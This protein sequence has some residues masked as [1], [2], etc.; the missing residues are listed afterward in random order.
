[1]QRLIEGPIGRAVA[2]V[3]I[4][5]AWYWNMCRLDRAAGAKEAAR[6]AREEAALIAS[7]PEYAAHVKRMDALVDGVV[8]R[9]T[10]FARHKQ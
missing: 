1:M 6:K 2:L 5:S 10:A 8:S 3:A 4:I 9:A 7:S